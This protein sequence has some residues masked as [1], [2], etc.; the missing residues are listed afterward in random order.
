M[1]ILNIIHHQTLHVG[2]WDHL[3]LLDLKIII[4]EEKSLA[5]IYNLFF[6]L[7][8]VQFTSFTSTKSKVPGAKMKPPL[9]HPETDG[10][11]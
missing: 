6:P 1:L 11:C 5:S 3:V 2:L 10:N 8:I 4:K 9:E 7:S